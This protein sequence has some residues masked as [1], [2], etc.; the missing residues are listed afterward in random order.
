M[1][2]TITMTCNAYLTGGIPNGGIPGMP[3]GG[4]PGIPIGGIPMPPGGMPMPPG[5]M[6]MPPGGMPMPPGII[7]VLRI[8]SKFL[9][10]AGVISVFTLVQGKQR[11]RRGVCFG[12]RGAGRYAGAGS[13]A[14]WTH[15]V[16][17][18]LLCCLL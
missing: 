10:C 12:V 18:R 3:L 16:I 13:G 15:R 11:A 9:I 17:D 14:E 5:G 4:M 7:P 8:I 1:S 2:V 6:P